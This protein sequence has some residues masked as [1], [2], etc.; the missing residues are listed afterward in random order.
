MRGKENQG[1]RTDIPKKSWECEE[2]VCRNLP[3][4]TRAKLAL[5]LKP[6]YAAKAKKNQIAGG[7]DKVSEKAGLQKSAKAVEPI[8]TRAAIAKVAGVSHNRPRL[9]LNDEK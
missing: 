1:T 2:R 4:Y 5:E 8:D 3:N 7:G 9:V 6:L